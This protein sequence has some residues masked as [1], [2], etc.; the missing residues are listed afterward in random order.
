MLLAVTYSKE[1]IV[2][3]FVILY[4]YSGEMTDFYVYKLGQKWF[5]ET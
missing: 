2:R 1:L 5:F 3:P 4:V